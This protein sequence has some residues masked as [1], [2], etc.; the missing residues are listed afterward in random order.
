MQSVPNLSFV[1]ANYDL[2]L[3]DLWGVVHDGSHLYPGVK[4]TL[5]TLRAEG[6]T[7]I[8]I[9]NAPRRAHKAAKVLGELGI[10]PELYRAVVTS[11]EVGYQWVAAGKS[12]W[13]K[14]YYF[15]GPSKDADVLDGLGLKRVD[16][17]KGADFLLNVGFGSEEQTTD[18]Y[19]MLLRGANAQ[20]LPMLCL[21]PD[22]EVVKITG[23]R[24][25]CAGVIGRQYEA[26]G[27]KV[28]W[29][30]K[31]YAEI[32][33]F[34]LAQVAAVDKS[35]ILAVGDS[36]ETDIPGGQYFGVDTMLVTGGIL[37]HYSA[38][39]VQEMCTHLRLHPNY[40]AGSLS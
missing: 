6:K 18:D 38:A 30:G 39:Q 33:E 20:G 2:F 12:P 23:E 34:C 19:S 15:I 22:L 37:K 7:V 16:D 17:I 13:G 4:A 10:P 1:S 24:F 9:S 31:P 27:S 5:E 36:L 3:L 14:R 25:P 28:T 8:F 11:G 26:L 21:N 35:R 29:F 32:Y 40:V